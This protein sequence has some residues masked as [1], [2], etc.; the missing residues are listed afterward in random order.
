MSFWPVM[1]VMVRSVFKSPET[2]VCFFADELDLAT[3][4][5]SARRGRGLEVVADEALLCRWD[6][7]P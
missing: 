3:S 5:A 1:A 4:R 7:L 2:Q 6:F